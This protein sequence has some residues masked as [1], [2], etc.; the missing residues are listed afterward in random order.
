MGVTKVL[1][2]IYLF[3]YLLTILV[4]GFVVLV[5]KI[6][7][8]K[9]TLWLYI[10]WRKID[11]DGN[12]YVPLGKRGEMHNKKGLLKLSKCQCG[13]YLRECAFMCTGC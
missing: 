5:Y 13:V 12:H 2:H 1:M 4:V 10:V 3:I 9:C 8:L 11:C 7:H 6:M